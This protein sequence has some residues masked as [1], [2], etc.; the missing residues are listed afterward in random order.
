MDRTTAR[1]I[2]NEFT[3][4]VDINRPD[5]I[6]RSGDVDKYVEKAL[7][8]LLE[9]G[10]AFRNVNINRR[11]GVR[12]TRYSY[13]GG[14]NIQ[15]SINAVLAEMPAALGYDVDDAGNVSGTDRPPPLSVTN[16]GRHY[17][18]E[19][20]ERIL[21]PRTVA[22]I[23]ADA[24]RAGGVATVDKASGYTTTLLR[25]GLT[26][27]TR[28][29][30]KLVTDTDAQYLAGELPSSALADGA[31]FATVAERARAQVAR[32]SNIKD[33]RQEAIKA[34][35]AA[36]PGSALAIEEVLRTQKVNNRQDKARMLEARRKDVRLRRGVM[37]AKNFAGRGV[38]IIFD[39]ISNLIRNGLKIL[40]T[41]YTATRD[42]G[43]QLR[44]NASDSL[45]FNLDLNTMKG[46]QNWAKMFPTLGDGNKDIMSKIMGALVADWGVITKLNTGKLGG[47]APYIH[48]AGVNN[49]ADF[50]TSGAL[51]P[52]KLAI[53]LL[54]IFIRNVARQNDGI[55]SADTR[56]GTIT[57]VLADADILGPEFAKL[58]S[59]ILW[60]AE[61]LEASEK[62]SPWALSN[63]AKSGVVAAG[64]DPSLEKYQNTSGVKS[65]ATENMAEKNQGQWSSF[66]NEL[67]V[68]RN[69]LLTKLL[70]NSSG[71]LALLKNFV[72]LIS[73]KF[74]PQF[75]VRMMEEAEERKAKF[76]AIV[77]GRLAESLPIAGQW[78]AE[79]GPK[80]F[81][82]TFNAV[83]D[84]RKLQVTE[85]YL[86]KLADY[87]KTKDFDVLWDF[88]FTNVNQAHTAITALALALA[89]IE[90]RRTIQGLTFT[91]EMYDNL[92]GVG[93]KVV[94]K[95]AIGATLYG[96]DMYD[97]DLLEQTDTMLY[98]DT[99]RSTHARDVDQGLPSGLSGITV[100]H[101]MIAPVLQGA[102]GA[103]IALDR[104][105][106]RNLYIP[107]ARK[108]NTLLKDHA[109]DASL[110]E[111][112]KNYR[113][114]DV[115]DFINEFVSVDSVITKLNGMIKGNGDIAGRAL[116]QSS[117]VREADVRIARE[118]A[119]YIRDVL[120]YSA[121]PLTV[122][123]ADREIRGSRF[124]NEYR[125][126]I[127]N[128]L[129]PY[130]ANHLSL[131][132]RSYL[133]RNRAAYSVEGER[134]GKSDVLT[135]RIVGPDGKEW[136][137]IRYN[138][139]I[140]SNPRVNLPMEVVN[141]PLWALSAV[142]P[143]RRD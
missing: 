125:E 123:E 92:P 84:H 46:Y 140:D 33:A 86:E 131:T 42:V 20:R 103:F 16:Q 9:A 124:V 132:E 90:N 129:T 63:L 77:R 54:D 80:S 85:L 127:D 22:A 7:Q 71:L 18:N 19:T 44:K 15:D 97:R 59:A 2:F 137:T 68:V 66:L 6:L 128:D 88:G 5:G 39:T 81:R 37:K 101:D 65:S 102:L 112:Q 87:R 40:G 111:L 52:D 21:N 126:W 106:D 91:Q 143:V 25:A 139:R 119:D 120:V 113:P 135:I 34:Y 141:I 116:H 82:D 58:L 36:N 69:D 60:E 105:R 110:A 50:F 122:Q 130:L 104:P 57:R 35:I 49:I 136:K 109:L 99:V 23:R 89:D 98:L 134:V 73:A 100:P 11:A 121:G 43:D 1:R 67:D 142:N 13:Q 93:K 94:S 133:D 31:S 72:M 114:E 3:T 48:S 74:F 96:P 45:R 4:E 17:Y 61:R 53:Q 76:D 79:N 108:L 24:L 26:G 83:S 30:R 47:I 41:I 14:K 10:K 12:S 118:T 115:R 75:A 27:E 107:M 28:R 138:D 55:W 56:R 38:H 29:L 117:R 64:L 95:A 8:P 51:A 70:A 62:D 78:L 32:Q